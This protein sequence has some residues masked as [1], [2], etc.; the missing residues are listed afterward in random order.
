MSKG[1]EKIDEIISIFSWK[2]D[3]LIKD[4]KETSEKAYASLSLLL[5]RVLKSLEQVVKT[6]VIKTYFQRA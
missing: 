6:L 3:Q 2:N 5:T 1:I 4:K